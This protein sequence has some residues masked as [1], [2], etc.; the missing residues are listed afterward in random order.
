MCIIEF[1]YPVNQKNYF[2]ELKAEVD[3]SLLYQNQTL[4]ST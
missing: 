4:S 3:F 1:Y 2:T